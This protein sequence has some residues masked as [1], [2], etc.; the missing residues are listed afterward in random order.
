[1]ANDMDA[2]FDASQKVKASDTQLSIIGRLIQE[3]Q[4]AEG[5]IA[6]AEEMLANAKERKRTIL[7][8]T[9]PQAMLDAGMREF[10]TSDGL[11]AKIAFLTDGS[12][13]PARNAEELAEREAKIDCIIENG[14]GEIVK[15]TV[16]IEFP[17]EY[18]HMAEELR[19][20]IEKLLQTKKWGGINAAVTRER[21]VNHQ[22]LGSWIRER[23]ES[24]D[25]DE[26]LPPEFF[27]ITGIWYGE[28]V[29]MQQPRKPK[30]KK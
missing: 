12:L 18:A 30:E 23:M 9:L 1:M 16:T 14:G 21:S 17:K 27:E 22:T 3:E 2:L 11:K 20:R 19:G 6:A 5:E 7:L 4:E 25:A 26:Q 28:G 15:Q 24:G 8:N 10:V 29:K 13:G